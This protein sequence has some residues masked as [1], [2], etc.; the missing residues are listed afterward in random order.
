[1]TSTFSSGGTKDTHMSLSGS[2]DATT[3]KETTLGF[4]DTT[5]ASNL[6]NALINGS[7]LN[8]TENVYTVDCNNV[9]SKSGHARSEMRLKT[10]WHRATYI[11]IRHE[12]PDDTKVDGMTTPYNLLVQ[13]RSN[14]KDYCPGKLDPTPGG[15]VG[16]G[17]SYELNAQ[18]E[19]SEEMNIDVTVKNGIN[20]KGNSIR[21]L[22]TFPYQ[23]DKVKCWGGMFE[24][25]YRGKLSDIK[26]Q[27][28]EVSDILRLSLDEIRMMAEK[29]P[30]DWMPDGLH[31]IQLYLQ[32]VRDIKLNRRLIE[33]YRGS[34]STSYTLRPKPKA[35]FF[36]CDDCLYFD[37]WKVADKLTA[38]IEDWCTKKKQLPEG[39]AYELYKKYGTA[40]RGLLA[41][42]LLEESDEA[43]DDYLKDV[44]DLPIVS[45]Q[46]LKRDGALRE[47][48]LKIDP[49]IPKYVFTA[50]VKD[51]AQRCLKALG[52]EDLFKEIIDVKSCNLVTKHSKEAF[53]AAMCIAGV[54][55]PESCI[56]LDD[57]IKNIAAARDMG[58]R[59][60]LVGRVERDSGKTISSEYAEHEIDRI[61]EMPDVLPELFS[62]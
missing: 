6:Q 31:A 32:Y 1:M 7:T 44:H 26:M 21:H 39:K 4:V 2:N 56:F 18:R 60:I 58:W 11:V 61:H 8:A 62:T 55:D 25:V 13:R 50:S 36:D 54:D 24:V 5:N 19:I 35:I 15:V 43:I 27:P 46:L 23:D 29:N 17:E 14:I 9:P 53:E 37:G 30:H 16:Y 22:F 12:D 38:K 47:M 34:C 59:S 3:S 10:L 40:L 57:S 28:E 51:H 52:I 41:E 49:S 48:L 42:D 45:E 33:G 20:D